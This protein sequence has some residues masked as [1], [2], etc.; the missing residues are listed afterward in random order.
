MADL[1]AE[2]SRIIGI[3]VIDGV[4]AAVKFLEA[5]VNLGLSTSKVGDLAYPIPKLYT[6][7]LA[8]FAPQ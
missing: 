1:S 4:T 6:G 3:P 8:P 5:L 7:M 2:I